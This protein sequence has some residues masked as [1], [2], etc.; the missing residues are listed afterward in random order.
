MKRNAD[1]YSR[2][3]KLRDFPAR[4]VFKLEEMQERFSLLKAGQKVLDL[5]SAPGSWSKFCLQRLGPKGRLVG[6]DL[7]PVDIQDSSGGGYRFLQCD[8]FSDSILTTL[9]NLG[10]FDVILSDA[11]PRTSG[12]GLVDAQRSLEIAERVVEIALC[13]LNPGGHLVIKVFQGGE[14]GLLLQ[15]MK[16]LFHRARAFKPKASRGESRETYY[17]GLFFGAKVEKKA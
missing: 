8:I 5:G 12:S 15:R 7:D 14:E 3:A 17:L 16:S 10:P 9:G 13:T 6:V 1:Y 4:S 2:L 11:A